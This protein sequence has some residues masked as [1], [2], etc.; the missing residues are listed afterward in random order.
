MYKRLFTWLAVVGICLALPAQ[1]KQHMKT[2]DTPK[3]LVTYFS[4][5]GNTARAAR[6]IAAATGA[7]LYEIR[8]AQTYTEKDL[9]W[10]DAHSR[11][12]VEMK[13]PKARPAI[14]TPK[15]DVEAYDVIFI[16]YPIWWDLAPTVVNTFIESQLLFSTLI[17]VNGR[18][19]LKINKVTLCIWIF[20]W[21]KLSLHHVRTQETPQ[22]RCL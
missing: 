10:H 20:G 12:S 7:D 22:I 2:S 13:D 17:A 4:A 5:T 8:P 16:G 3:A 6:L 19:S 14:Q 11:S 21:R 18:K 15:A 1:S 9:D